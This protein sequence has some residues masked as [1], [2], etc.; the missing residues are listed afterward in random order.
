MSQ[1]PIQWKK[2]TRVEKFMDDT[3]DYHYWNSLSE[4]EYLQKAYE[5]IEKSRSYSIEEAEKILDEVITRREQILKSAKSA[6]EEY[7]FLE[8]TLDD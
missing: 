8:G 4:K 2:V 6:K 5:S 1:L 7:D 3:Y